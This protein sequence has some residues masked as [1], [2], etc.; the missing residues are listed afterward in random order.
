MYQPLASL[1]R[2][3]VV[4][5]R[6]ANFQG[7]RMVVRCMP[8][9]HFSPANAS[10]LCRRLRNLFTNQGAQV[11][12]EVPE[13]GALLSGAEAGPPSAPPDLI[14]ETR[15]RQVHYD[16]SKLLWAVSICTGTLV[17]AVTETTVALDVAVR[18][19]DGALLAADTL[20][21]RFVR[22]TSVSVWTVNSLLNWLVRS[23]EE[24]LGDKTT[25]RD[26]S[27][28]LYGQV[29]QLAFHA[30]MRSLVMRGFEPAATRAP[31]PA[32]S[33]AFQPVPAPPPVPGPLPVPAPPP[34][35]GPV[36]K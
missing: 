23:D 18:G 11:E 24:D 30:H 12:L 3:V 29:S 32:T 19:H 16:N 34:V 10:Y 9:E 33:A 15:S 28:D 7:L 22:Y 4:D 6:V 35:P 25:R 5:P 8:G 17:P 2:P 31:A 26:F 14:V 20:Q 21:A 13:P 1:Q 36:P 27:R